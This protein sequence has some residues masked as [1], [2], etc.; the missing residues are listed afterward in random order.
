MHPDLLA[1]QMPQ[2]WWA[3]W[4]EQYNREP[5]TVAP[6]ETADQAWETLIKRKNEMLEKGED[7]G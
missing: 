7:D 4:L 2:E 6:Q 5:W 3:E 1:D